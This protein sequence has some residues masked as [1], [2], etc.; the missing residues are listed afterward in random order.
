MWRS[1]RM[2]SAFEL[3]IGS[4]DKGLYNI[5]SNSRHEVM[6]NEVRL[7]RGDVM[8]SRSSFIHPAIHPFSWC[9]RV[10]VTHGWLHMS[11][12]LSTP[13]PQ[14]LYRH[15]S[16]RANP[17]THLLHPNRGEIRK[18]ESESQTT[19]IEG[20]RKNKKQNKKKMH[21]NRSA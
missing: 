21:L 9:S 19:S 2:Y 6:E 4:Y 16:N 8:R 14:P 12:Q 5:A 1:R 20:G 10:L 13:C 11:P 7:E 3:M 17:P 18:P 15:K